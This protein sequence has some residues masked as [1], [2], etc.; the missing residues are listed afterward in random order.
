MAKQQSIVDQAQQ[1]N[2]AI[3]ALIVPALILG[4]KHFNFPVD[5][6]IQDAIG[7]LATGFLVYLIPNRK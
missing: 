1:Y 2:K 6:S 7:V 5:Q 4:L 3:V